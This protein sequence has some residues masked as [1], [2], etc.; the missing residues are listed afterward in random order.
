MYTSSK[1]LIFFCLNLQ[2]SHELKLGLYRA[3]M[4][5]PKGRENGGY[6]LYL[7]NIESPKLI[8]LLYF[9]IGEIMIQSGSQNT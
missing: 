7:K 6:Y 3:R 9:D 1:E 8:I 5:C 4:V 2:S